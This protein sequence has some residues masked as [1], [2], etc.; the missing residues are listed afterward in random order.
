MEHYP[1]KF[2]TQNTLG[3]M[4]PKTEIANVLP[5][6]S[7]PFALRE[8][9]ITIDSRDRDTSV[10][11]SPS[12]F[13]VRMEP[14]GSFAGATLNRNYKNIKSIELVSAVYPNTNNVLKEMY[15]YLVIPEI[16]GVYDAT[17]RA[18]LNAFAKLIPHNTVGDYVYSYNDYIE[19]QKKIYNVRGQR[20]DRL[21]LQ[22]AKYDGTTFDFSAVGK[23]IETSVTLKIVTVD[24]FFV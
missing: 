5:D 13:Q 11:P 24:P 15:L 16:D 14:D 2:S 1:Q 10:W 6:T 12:Y 19:R 4:N 8:T 20:L 23:T 17:N 22:F 9:Y 21:T 7:S 18:G 3:L